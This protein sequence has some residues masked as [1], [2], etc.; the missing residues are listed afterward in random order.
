MTGPGAMALGADMEV[1]KSTS[2]KQL[3][4]WQEATAGGGFDEPFGSSDE[5][6]TVGAVALDERGG[7]AAGSSTGG[8]FGKLA[9]RTGDAP[10]FGAGVYASHSAAVVGTGIGEVFL[11][12]LA[13]ARTGFLIERGADPQ[14]AC[15]EVVALLGRH[16][17]FLAALLAIDANGRVGAAYRGGDLVIEGR[18]GL[19]ETAVLP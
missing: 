3:L 9:G 2:D 17:P 14:D 1:L 7:L 5:I 6:D 13:S 12:N 8:V 15:A 11:T 10:I 19:V 16:E 18:D 4:R